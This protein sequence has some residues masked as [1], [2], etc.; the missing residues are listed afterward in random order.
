MN[1]LGP[2]LMKIGG[3]VTKAVQAIQTR[4]KTLNTRFETSI[5]EYADRASRLAAVET[6]HKARKTEVDALTAELN[7]VIGRLS[8]V[9]ED[10]TEKQ[11]EVSDNS[12]LIKIRGAISKL[13]EQIKALELRSAI[14]QR[15]LTQTWQEE[16][17]T[18]LSSDP[19]I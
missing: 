10:L 3:D 5:A 17:E 13:R 9:K 6:R 14:L 2:I 15:T 11:K 1:Q 7:D 19:A 4:E 16:K 12:P 8:N 18:G